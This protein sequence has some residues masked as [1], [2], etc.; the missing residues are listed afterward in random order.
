MTITK[1]GYDAELR[2]TGRRREPAARR[3]RAETPAGTPGE[4]TVI[5]CA[6][7]L[8]RHGRRVDWRRTADVMDAVAEAGR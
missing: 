8:R 3:R 2:L 7:F 5:D 1:A 6:T 4:G